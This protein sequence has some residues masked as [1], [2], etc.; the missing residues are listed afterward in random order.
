MKGLF[1][2]LA[3]VFLQLFLQRVDAGID[4]LLKTLAL[5]AGVKVVAAQ[6]ETDVGNLVFGSV[7]VVEFQ[8]DFGADDVAVLGAKLFQFLGDEFFKFLVSLEVD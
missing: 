4:R 1:D 7:G 8:R 2:S 6:N 3:L 5:L